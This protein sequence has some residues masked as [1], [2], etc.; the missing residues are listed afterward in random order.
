[1]SNS[2]WGK[3]NRIARL[4]CECGPF[5]FLALD[6]GLTSGTVAGLDNVARWAE[7]ADQQGF[8]GVV[9]NRGRVSG[10]NPLRRANLILQAVGLPRCTT[11]HASRVPVATV[12]DALRYDATALAVQVRFAAEDLSSILSSVANLMGEAD[13]L[14]IPVLLMVNIEDEDY[15]ASHLAKYIRMAA[16]LGADLIK[17]PLPAGELGKSELC[18]IRGVVENSPP[19]LLAGG[20][21]DDEFIT[22]LRVSASLGFSG[23]CVGRNVFQ[24]EDPVAVVDAIREAYT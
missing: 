16:E 4:R 15:G 12:A 21:T 18:Q 6:H 9:V 7:F 13:G 3:A 24:A 2:G 22:R 14:S 8:S 20:G 10:L 1:M 5:L 11:G 23:A 19:V 17:I